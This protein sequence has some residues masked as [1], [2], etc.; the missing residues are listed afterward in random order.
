MKNDQ[1]DKVEQKNRGDEEAGETTTKAKKP[2]KAPG[3][4][5]AGKPRRE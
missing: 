4:A 3:E 1:A 2:I 5:K